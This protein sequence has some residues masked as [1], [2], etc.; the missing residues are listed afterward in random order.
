MNTYLLPASLV[1]SNSERSAGAIASD[2]MVAPAATM[3]QVGMVAAFLL[4]VL[5]AVVLVEVLRR[6]RELLARARARWDHFA[7]LARQAGLEEADIE[8]MR[9][10]HMDMDAMHAPDAMLRIPAVYDRA[11]EAWI[12]SRGGAISEREWQDLHR[13][14][15]KLKFHSLSSETSLSHTRQ[16]S[17][18][19][20]VRLSTEEGDWAGSGAVCNNREDRLEVLVKSLPPP[21]TSRLRL[22]FSRQG[23]GEYKTVLSISGM[24]TEQA[25][26]RFSHTDQI[27]RQQLRMWV[28][29]PV[30][31]PGKMRRVVSP[32]GTSHAFD[33]FDV[34][35]LDL[36]GGGAMV[37]SSKM[38]EVESRGL[39]D[40]QL[41]ENR[42]E[43]LRFVMLRSG[44]AQRGGTGH[45]CHLCFESI[46][47][48][49]Q[50]R[51]MRYVFERQRAGRI[52]G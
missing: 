21:G 34:T 4:A 41:G 46:D 33:E 9:T 8:R 50:E 37:S 45:V 47:V 24:E 14:R 38:M 35:L 15:V 16:I 30:L 26:L 20:E 27:V 23:D 2:I 48:Q 49:T 17:D 5:V 25:I 43:G 39:L 3:G 51:I 36:S 6:R 42:L 11:L 28:R 22:A 40:F 7:G 12:R 19:Q 32:D 10:M 1:S 44:R 31:L 52:T 29:V 18:H 13:V